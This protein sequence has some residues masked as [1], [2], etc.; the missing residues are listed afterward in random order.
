[1][2][3]GVGSSKAVPVTLFSAKLHAFKIGDVFAIRGGGGI[4]TLYMGVYAP[5]RQI[6][7]TQAE[8]RIF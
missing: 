1:M 7:W 4:L 8:I 3:V 6:I 5:C 2:Q